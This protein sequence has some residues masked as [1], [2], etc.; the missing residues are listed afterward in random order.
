MENKNKYLRVTIHDNDFT[1][2]LEQVCELLYDTF[3]REDKYPTE[4]NFPYLQTAIQYMWCGATM[5]KDIMRWGS[6]HSP[7]FKYLCPDLKIVDLSEIYDWE[8]Y[9]I[10]YIP[11][12]DDGEIIV[13]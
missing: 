5:A 13:R 7:S 3:Q 9:E 12:F 11:L 4:A 6:L 2:T 10:V 8:N 1:T